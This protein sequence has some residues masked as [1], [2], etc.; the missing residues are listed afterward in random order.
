MTFHGHDGNLA[1]R[2]QATGVWLRLELAHAA[3]LTLDLHTA[4]P[5]R[6]ALASD[7]DAEPTP[8]FW[9]LVKGL[10]PQ[11]L[12]PGFRPDLFAWLAGR[13]RTDRPP[14]EAQAVEGK[15]RDLAIHAAGTCAPGPRRAALRFCPHL[16]FRLYARFLGDASDRLLQMSRSCPG[17][18]IFAEAMLEQEGTSREVG[19]TLL[20]RVRQGVRLSRLLD[21]AVN[22]WADAMPEVIQSRLERGERSP[23]LHPV[24]E[25]TGAERA[26]LCRDQ[27]ILVRRAGP[28]VPTTLL[29][30]PPPLALVP[31]DIPRAVRTNAR[32]FRVMKGYAALLGEPPPG[33]RPA[34]EALSRLASRQ[35]EG[36]LA[37]P[38][39]RHR[40]RT[41]LALLRDHQ[42]ATG[43]RPGPDRDPEVLLAEARQWHQ[44]LHPRRRA[45]P[46][47]PAPDLALP[48]VPDSAWA[49]DDLVVRPLATAGELEAEGRRMRHCAASYV[50][51]ALAG[52]VHLFA[53][54]VR[55][56]R[57]TV[58][59]QRVGEQLHLGQ[60]QGERN[61][62]P[63][64]QEIDALRPWL[65]RLGVR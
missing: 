29:W 12:R 52:R 36:L 22:G 9:H 47:G 61:R 31:E 37:A 35:A 56:Q 30:L 8:P 49:A 41:K 17:A 34:L 40:P 15:L 4:H 6:L 33:L 7:P 24:A 59:L 20:G 10:G 11:G 62:D 18:L 1:W 48:T 51:Q 16:R 64:A 19:E 53:V 25:S 55:R 3:T 44:A 43:R 39:T 57:L 63:T 27:R 14:D 58:E 54:E 65:D 23:A 21:E 45:A 13:A 2:E 60:V 38:S 26:R 42:V 46:P 28:R 5:A 50:P 32:W